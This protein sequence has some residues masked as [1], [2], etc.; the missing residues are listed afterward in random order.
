[1]RPTLKTQRHAATEHEQVVW[2]ALARNWR[3]KAPATLRAVADAERIIRRLMTEP[4]ATLEKLGAEYGISYSTMKDV[5]KRAI[6]QR[7]VWLTRTRQESA[8]RPAGKRP[9][10]VPVGT[11][12]RHKNY[13]WIKVADT[14]RERGKSWRMVSRWLWETTYGPVPKGM[15]VGF[16]D[17]NGLNDAL[18]NL[19][20]VS[21]GQHFIEWQRANPENERRRVERSTAARRRT[22]AQ[23][24]AKRAAMADTTPV[25]QAAPLEAKPRT[26]K[27][28]ARAR[29]AAFLASLE[30]A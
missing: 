13:R 30:A 17:G 2:Q 20:L 5:V 6:K 16:K 22:A 19:V 24:K 4:G 23:Q 18:E 28:K 26:A 14:P 9:T 21:P 7:A 25:A 12:R 8:R 11:V 10:A 27:D 1:M 3:S 15:Q 29:V